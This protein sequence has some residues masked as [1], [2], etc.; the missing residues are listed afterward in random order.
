[1]LGDRAP[2]AAARAGDDGDLVLEPERRHGVLPFVFREHDARRETPDKA[3]GGRLGSGE[4]YSS[5][6]NSCSIVGS[7]S[8]TVGWMC[9]ARAITV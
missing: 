9:I 2:D 8:V 6:R 1:M 7:S 3:F 4:G 5:S